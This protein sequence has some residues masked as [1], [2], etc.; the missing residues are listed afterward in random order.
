[1]EVEGAV[2]WKTS[3]FLKTQEKLKR[4]GDLRWRSADKSRYYTWDS[5]HGEIEVFNRRGKHIA[6]LNANGTLSNKQPKQGRT[7]DD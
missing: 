5:M 3:T 7:I 1:M 4:S 6:V 2:H